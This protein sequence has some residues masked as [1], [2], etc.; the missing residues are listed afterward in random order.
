MAAVVR[1]QVGMTGGQ[2]VLWVQ[3]P[4]RTAFDY[5][6]LWLDRMFSQSWNP[7]HHLGALGFF[8]YWIVAA[9]G[10]YLYVFFDTGLTEAY[11]SVEYMTHD[12][13]YLAGVM[14]SLHRYASDAMVL[15]MVI[16][17]AREFA[18]DRYRGVRWFTWS[19][20]VP[21]IVLLLA[22][23]IT[24]YWLVWDRLAQFI[25][26]RSTE[27]LD[28]LPI[29]GTPTAANFLTPESLD[30]RFFSLMIF[31]HIAAP[32]I[33][34]LV[35]WIHLQR[36]S[37]PQINPPRGLAVGMFAMMIVL[38]LVKPAVSHGPADL[39]TVVSVVNLDWFYLGL[40][41]LVDYWSAGTVWAA[42]SLVLLI[43]FVMPWMP[44]M[45]RAPAVEVHLDHC[46]GCTRCV[47]DCP[48]GAVAM[49][50]R[51]DGAKFHLEAVVNPDLCVSCGI[52]VGS[53]PSS[54]PFR[55]RGAIET[56]IDLPHFPLSQLRH[57]TDEAA[58]R[59]KGDARVLVFG[60]EHGPGPTQAEEAGAAF[61]RLPCIGMLP[62]P[63]I[64]YVLSRDLADGVVLAGCANSDCYNRFGVEWTDARVDR[65]RDPRLRRRVPRE[66]LARLWAGRPEGD[67]LAAE[68]E[69]LAARLKTLE[70][71][72][73]S[74]VGASSWPVLEPVGDDH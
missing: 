7:L 4:I 41:P 46:N 72:P 29:F 28:W 49:Q 70:P 3:R 5:A 50:P 22:C 58:A 54:T 37:R 61:V 42:L 40:Y 74:R 26:V 44:P 11:A 60:C 18:L 19:T 33:L 73:A 12:Q 47:D 20:G 55:R 71:K 43:V 39:S 65:E 38:S 35:L 27:W 62:P 23:G 32:L 21:I 2:G 69:R 56:G 45:K 31:I 52:C 34:L 63:F 59:L 9:S 53:C 25:A 6:E 66:R 17:M 8:M 48:F 10:I 16:H 51:T 36:V 14:R 24:G 64:D 13:W 1:R 15:F 67:V 57:A 30:D 68:V